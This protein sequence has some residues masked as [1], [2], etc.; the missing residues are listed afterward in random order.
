VTQPRPYAFC[1]YCTAI[2]FFAEILHLAWEYFH[3]G[4]VAHHI[5]ART[6]LP[7][8]SNWWGLLLI[9]MLT[10]FITGL[11][12]R[13]SMQRVLPNKRRR[14]SLLGFAGALLFG[15]VLSIAFVTK[16]DNLAALLFQGVF[17]LSVLVPLYR[18]EYLLGFVFGMTFTFG[19]VLPTGIGV[20]VMAVAAI[21]HLLIYPLFMW[22][23]RVGKGVGSK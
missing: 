6:D 1:L 7:A 2:A 4:V 17:L 10:W 8:F 19:P 20:V 15:I 16:Q 11:I 14:Q 23:W 18:P 21:I 13:Q 22:I 9:P 3:G 5:L 12:E